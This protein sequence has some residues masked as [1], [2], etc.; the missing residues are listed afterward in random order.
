MAALPNDR[1]DPLDQAL[2]DPEVREKLSRILER[3]DRIEALVETFGTF[4]ERVP[5]LADAAGTTA[6]WAWAQAEAAGVDPIA[7]GRRG[8]Q[9][10]LELGK[11]EVLDMAERLLARRV[12]LERVLTAF[13]RFEPELAPL[14]DVGTTTAVVPAAE[15]EPLGLFGVLRKLGDSDVQKATG[16]LF[17]FA[18][19]FGRLLRTAG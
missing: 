10:L 9:L 11:P 2:R 3:L 12:Q 8:A 15:V 16:L 5:T 13:D 18:K 14:L 17:A 6:T 4:A 7:S 1:T 19:R